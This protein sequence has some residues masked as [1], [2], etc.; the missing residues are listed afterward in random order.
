MGN[1][2]FSKHKHEEKQKSKNK[3]KNYRGR[4]E[5]KKLF[6]K[7]IEEWEIYIYSMGKYWRYMFNGKIWVGIEDIGL[8]GKYE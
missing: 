6:T 8:M 4:I 7:K 5:K 2:T 1:K 3:S